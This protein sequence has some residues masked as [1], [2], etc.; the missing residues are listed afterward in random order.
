[1]YVADF[2]ALRSSTSFTDFQGLQKEE[3]EKSICLQ[4]VG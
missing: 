4:N 3:E 1:M 2:L